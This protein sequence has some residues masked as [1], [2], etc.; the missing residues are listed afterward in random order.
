[1]GEKWKKIL[2]N[3]ALPQPWKLHIEDGGTSTSLGFR[4]TNWRRGT[5]I[6]TKYHQWMKIKF[7]LWLNHYTFRS[8]IWQLAHPK[9]YNY[10]LTHFTLEENGSSKSTSSRSRLL[11]NIRAET[12]N[13]SDSKV[14]AINPYA[15]LLSPA[16]KS[17]MFPLCKMISNLIYWRMLNATSSLRIKIILFLV[18]IFFMHP[19]LISTF[20]N[21]KFNSG[22][23][24]CSAASPL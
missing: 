14:W 18:I 2:R 6:T 3:T 8:L 23:Q 17:S 21:Y 24:S 22:L 11:V 15:L 16:V 20:R 1:M 4:M 7:L 9:Y 13:Q 10:Y 5:S 12:W 19:K